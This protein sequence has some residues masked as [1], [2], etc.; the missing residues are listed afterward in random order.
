MV[1]IGDKQARHNGNF[2][3]CCLRV[4]LSGAAKLS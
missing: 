1:H 3:E 4:E 2:G